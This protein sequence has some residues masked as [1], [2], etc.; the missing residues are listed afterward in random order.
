MIISSGL[1]TRPVTRTSSKKPA[2]FADETVEAPSEKFETV[3]AV[4]FVSP[5]RIK[6]VTPDLTRDTMPVCGS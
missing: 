1:S 2:T 5:Y 3:R 6:T 4:S